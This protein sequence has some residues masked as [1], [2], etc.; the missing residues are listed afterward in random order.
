[1]T[2]SLRH[3]TR[4]AGRVVNYS[5]D[6]LSLYPEGPPTNDFEHLM[7]MLNL[8]A[9]SSSSYIRVDDILVHALF[10]SK[11]HQRSYRAFLPA[12]AGD[13][14][15][16]S[17]EEAISI[18]NVIRNEISHDNPTKEQCGV[19]ITGS[20]FQRILISLNSMLSDFTVMCASVQF[21]SAAYYYVTVSS[22]LFKAK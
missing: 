11:C 5:V 19:C 6:S 17:N 10:T 1:M 9:F 2:M 3:S 21:H 13:N 7:H 16:I 8:Q 22:I 14:T 15:D 4:T 20:Y 12:M 18:S